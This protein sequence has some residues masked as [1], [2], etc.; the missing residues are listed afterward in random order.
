MKK[1]HE[2]KLVITGIAVFVLLNIPFIFI[3]DI[4]GNVLGIPV[5]YVYIFLVWSLSITI[6]YVVLK[7]Y[8]E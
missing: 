2:Q 6:S 5:L 8:Y 1:R 3:F 7:R 4:E